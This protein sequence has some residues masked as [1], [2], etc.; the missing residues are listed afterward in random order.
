MLNFGGLPALGKNSRATDASNS[1]PAAFD[2]VL[3]L[4]PPTQH[5]AF[6]QANIE[7]IE[8]YRDVSPSVG[9]GVAAEVCYSTT[10][11]KLAASIRQMQRGIRV[12]SASH[13]WLMQQ[14]HEACHDQRKLPAL[15]LAS[16]LQAS[17]VFKDRCMQAKA[18]TAKS[19]H[20]R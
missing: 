9:T 20:D 12:S 1:D 19:A 15:L 3:H 13:I 4:I 14:C 7:L 10:V 11:G 5:S 17:E 6:Q 18:Q 8:F 16:H 2:G